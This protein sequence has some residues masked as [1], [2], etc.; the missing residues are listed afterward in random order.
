M[1]LVVFESYQL[2][3]EAAGSAILGELLWDPRLLVTLATGKTPV[4]AYAE[5]TRFRRRYGLSFPHVRV[6]KLDEW[7]GVPMDEAG[8][9]EHF[10]SEHVLGP[11]GIS[12]ENYAGFHS[13]PDSSDKECC[14]VHE[15]LEREGPIGLAVLG[16]GI[17]GHIGFN[18]PGES[19]LLHSHTA[20]LSEASRGHDMV[21]NRHTVIDKGITLGVADLLAARRILLL[22]S[23][24][25]KAHQ[26][27]QLFVGTVTTRQP[28][29]L[30]HLHSNVVCFCDRA[31]AAELP[32]GVKKQ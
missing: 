19:L 31:A 4:G 11:W 7:I 13:S 27:A 15:R 2:M 22:V 26:L 23:G 17:N 1:K 3:S 18:E 9:C 16:V 6:L 30:L 24:E 28:A 14:S 5:V 20:E 29:T 32:K 12:R 10:I 21:S 25:H 8:S